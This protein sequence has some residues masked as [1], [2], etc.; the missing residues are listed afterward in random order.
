MTVKVGVIVTGGT[1]AATRDDQGSGLYAPRCGSELLA[2][3]EQIGRERGFD[4]CVERWL[5][6]SGEVQPLLDS[7]DVRPHHWLHIDRQVEQLLDHCHGVV[8]LHGTD[9]LAYSASA[10]G[11]LN[12]RRRGALVITGAQIPLVVEGSDAPGNLSA[13][14]DAAAGMYGDLE[15]DT[16]VAFGGQLMRGVRVSKHSTESFSG[17]KSWNSAAMRTSRGNPGADVLRQW[18][19]AR[20][21]C[22]A[23][24]LT[25]F[26][27]GVLH[28][29]A[30]P[31]MDVAWL[32]RV[33]LA[34]PPRGV[35][36]ELYGVGSA[37]GASTLAQMADQ[38]AM[39]NVPVVAVSACRHG[40]VDWQRYEATQP[41]RD[42][43]MMSAGNMTGEAA[44]VKLAGLLA[45][46]EGVVPSADAA[47]TPN[48]SYGGSVEHI[49]ERFAQ[50]ITAESEC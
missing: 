45:D 37:P 17:F 49:A 4:V 19:S 33:L 24:R 32:S 11:M 40:A 8:V 13:A 15:G 46:T 21:A 50:G 48:P 36:I 31:A 28:L 5:D 39:H 22:Q 18:Q 2:M 38:L 10:L 16:V 20:A 3:T 9:T 6:A 29:K 26:V 44:A 1:I 25:D 27:E 7:S 23:P 34:E 30:S 12:P 43:A 35:V 14:I 47:V 42:S 41:L